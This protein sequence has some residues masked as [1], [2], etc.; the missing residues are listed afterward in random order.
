M[1]ARARDPWTL[2]ERERERE[3]ERVRGRGRERGREHVC[4]AFQQIRKIN[5]D[6]IATTKHFRANKS[7]IT[8]KLI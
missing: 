5:T 8:R 4:Y 3:R 7:N 2:P 1:P 6:W